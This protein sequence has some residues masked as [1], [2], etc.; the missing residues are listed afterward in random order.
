[1]AQ[2]QGQAQDAAFGDAGHGV[3]VVQAEG[4]NGAAEQGDDAVGNLDTGQQSN[5]SSQKK[6]G[7]WSARCFSII[8]E[9]GGDVHGEQT[10]AEK[11][12]HPAP[13]LNA[14]FV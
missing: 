11:E 12:R 5:K 9:I 3:D 4:Q 8:A 6:L 10:G 13:G 1:M 14:A 2:Q 7:Q